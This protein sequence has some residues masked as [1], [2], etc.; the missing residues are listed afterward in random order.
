MSDIVGKVSGNLVSAVYANAANARTRED[1]EHRSRR[2][3]AAGD[4]LAWVPQLRNL[5]VTLESECDKA[6]WDETMQTAFASMRRVR[7]T[8]P[9]QWKH[10][11]HSIFDAIGNGTG[12]IV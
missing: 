3:E 11:H 2:R 10:L 1:E 12:A 4:L 7:G 5:L 6:T 8:M 9:E